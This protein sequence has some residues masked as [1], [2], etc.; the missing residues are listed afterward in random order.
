MGDRKVVKT[1]DLVKLGCYGTREV[2]NRLPTD[3]CSVHKVNLDRKD[4]DTSFSLDDAKT[5]WKVEVKG[6]VYD[7][8]RW[9]AA[10]RTEKFN[11]NTYILIPLIRCREVIYIATDK[12]E[13]GI[14]RPQFLS[15][16]LFKLPYIL[17]D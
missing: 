11:E 6:Y 5:F 13:L 14:T 8:G 7:R 3:Q 1:D 2:A 12:Y 9:Y 10:V 15:I 4:L 16:I 17:R